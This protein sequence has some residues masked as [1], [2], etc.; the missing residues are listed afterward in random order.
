MT[1]DNGELDLK[2]ET[3]KSAETLLKEKKE[4]F[5]KEPDRFVDMK[6][7]IACMVRIPG[8][9]SHYIG[10]AK[11]SEYNM[12]KSELQYQIDKILREM[13]SMKKSS[14]INPF[15]KKGAFGKKRF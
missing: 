12:T 9:V 6:D 1:G 8:G 10:P 7:I 4:A 15:A 5:E 13:D 11:R 2:K 14:I 3:E